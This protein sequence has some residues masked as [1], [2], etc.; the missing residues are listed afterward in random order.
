MGNTK[1]LIIVGGGTKL[2]DPFSVAAKKI[3]LDL[4]TAGFSDLSYESKK[5]KTV[6]LKV[7]DIPVSDFDVI[8]IRLVGKRQEECALLVEYANQKGIKVVDSAFQKNL[9]LKIPY[10]KAVET[11]ILTD[12]GVNMPKTYFGSLENIFKNA[13]KIFGYPFVIKGTTGKQ[14]HAVWSPRNSYELEELKQVLFDV[15]EKKTDMKFI[16]QEFIEASQ[17]SR[18]FVVGGK[19]LTAITRP[20]RW[21]KRFLDKVEGVYPQ[22]ERKLLDPIPKEDLEIAQ[23]AAN[24]LFIDVAGVDVVTEDIT[25]E[26]YILEVNSAPRWESV[27]KDTGLN[28]EEEILKYLMSLSK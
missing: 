24:A 16:A 28:V 17:R 5:G 20:T 18:V 26:R 22:G 13:P 21:R 23:K 11:K 27:K 2:L 12:K 8:Y 19:A 15:R 6:E 7:K 25:G 10:P 3:S 14:G 4:V 1:I 9:S